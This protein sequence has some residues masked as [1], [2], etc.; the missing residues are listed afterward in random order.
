M[1]KY[2]VL[3]IALLLIFVPFNTRADEDEGVVVFDSEEEYEDDDLLVDDYY[4]EDYYDEDDEYY[5]DDGYIM[6][7]DETLDLDS[8]TTNCEKKLFT[9]NNIIFLAVGVVTGAALTIVA[10]VC[11]RGKCNC[12]CCCEEKEDKKKTKKNDK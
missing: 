2:L 10:V 8:T 1:K 7:A 3:L 11:T 6:E 9:S 4:E 12:A 5:Y